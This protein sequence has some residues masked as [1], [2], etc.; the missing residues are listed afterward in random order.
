MED[1]RIINFFGFKK[2]SEV[3]VAG[4]DIHHQGPG[5]GVVVHRVRGG[6]ASASG[7]RGCAFDGFTGE[8]EI[9]RFGRKLYRF[10]VQIAQRRRTSG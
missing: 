4:A 9:L 2:L 5:V 6:H 3:N 10:V 1:G 7:W 8:I